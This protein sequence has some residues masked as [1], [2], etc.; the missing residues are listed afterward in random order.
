[1]MSCAAVRSTFHD[2]CKATITQS[3]TI[4][5]VGNYKPLNVKS[6]RIFRTWVARFIFSFRAVN[7]FWQT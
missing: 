4:S 6:R 5:E 2:K 7:I 1:M 3:F